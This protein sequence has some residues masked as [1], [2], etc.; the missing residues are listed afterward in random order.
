MTK[1]ELE[2]DCV[3]NQ[4]AI[5]A[6][7]KTAVLED[8]VTEAHTESQSQQRNISTSCPLKKITHKKTPTKQVTKFALGNASKFFRLSICDAL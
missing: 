1:H 5:S 7:Q 3:Q 6:F 2:N 8:H 4:V